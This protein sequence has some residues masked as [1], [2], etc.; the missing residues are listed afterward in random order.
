MTRIVVLIAAAFMVALTADLLGPSAQAAG[1]AP[2]FD[3]AQVDPQRYR[4]GEAVDAALPRSSGG[5]APVVYTLSDELPSGLSFNAETVSIVGTP[6]EQSSSA[7]YTLTA[8]DADNDLDSLTFT[9]EVAA[10]DSAHLASDPGPYFGPTAGATY[11]GAALH[12]VKG[13]EAA[14]TLQPAR[15]GSGTITYALHSTPSLPDGLRFD[16][17]SRVISGT[18]SATSD[19]ATF[20]L[21]ATDAD[22]NTASMTFTITVAH[23][24]APRVQGLSISSTPSADGAYTAGETITV[25]LDFTGPVT[26]SGTPRI[27]LDVGGVAR[28]ADFRSVD[29]RGAASFDYT[30]QE[31]DSDSDGIVVVGISLNGGVIRSVDN[32]LDASLRLQGLGQTT[33]TILPPSEPPPGPSG[34]SESG[35]ESSDPAPSEP[36]PPPQVD[37]VPSFGDAAGPS[38]SYRVDE[39]VDISLPRASGGDP[40]LAYDL[41][42][43]LPS[44]LEFSTS[45]V[46]ILGTPT[47]PSA[48]EDYFLSATDV[49][50]DSVR[51]SFTVE[52]VAAAQAQVGGSGDKAAAVTGVT[53]TSAPTRGIGSFNPYGASAN[54]DVE[55]TFSGPVTVTGSPQLALGI[56]SRI[57][58]AAYRS[59]SGSTVSFR[60]T[61]VGADRD[62]DGISIGASALTLNGGSI[63]V[64]GVDAALGLGRHVMGAQSDHTVNGG[65]ASFDGVQSPAYTFTRGVLHSVTLPAADSASKSCPG[66]SPCSPYSLAS[67]PALPGGLSFDAAARTISGTAGAAM[68]ETTYTLSAESPLGTDTLQFTIEVVNPTATVR[69]VTI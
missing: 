56:G 6:A 52:V 37:S 26:V 54:I 53:I 40:P 24:D 25:S 9:I 12:Y 28:W 63:K 46:S 13:M 38:L 3:G 1:S 49:D 30:V 27:S 42:P 20:T 50:G 17:A 23:E 22:G 5:D 65:G 60:Y 39:A 10:A 66:N 31:S 43:V 19:P 35:S 41:S 34:Q 51:L 45:T 44:G 59:A 8:T 67:A 61:V 14:D 11:Q 62:S 55:I 18:P 15:G 47:E 64:G 7:D 29:A 36:L 32:G 68:A 57:R 69:G 4:V 21:E 2:S 33:A 58:Q 48:I 16:A